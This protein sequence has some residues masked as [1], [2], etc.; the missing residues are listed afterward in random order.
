MVITRNY[1]SQMEN[2]VSP[3]HEILWVIDLIG[4]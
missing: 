4:Q 1:M 3:V 2:A